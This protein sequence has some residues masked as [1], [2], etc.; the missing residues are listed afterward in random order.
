MRC[1]LSTEHYYLSSKYPLTYI[2]L[3]NRLNIN[4]LDFMTHKHKTISQEKYFVIDWR[5]GDGR[6]GKKRGREG[7]MT[8]GRILRERT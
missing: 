4:H 7:N 3:F 2:K 8:D 5:K 1:G 6:E